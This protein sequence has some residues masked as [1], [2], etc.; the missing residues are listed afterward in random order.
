MACLAPVLAVL[1]TI[2]SYRLLR[3]LPPA[4]G[5]RKESCL[6][7]GEGMMAQPGLVMAMADG[8]VAMAVAMATGGLLNARKVAHTMSR[9]IAAMSDGQAF[10]ANLV[11]GLLVIA[12]SRFGLPVSTTHVCVGAITVWAS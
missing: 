10:T 5:V 11:S 9:E 4:L 2:A 7:V 8:N 1:A 3:H 12:A 6:C